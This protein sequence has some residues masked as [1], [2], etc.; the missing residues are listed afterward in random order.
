[1]FWVNYSESK[2][3][4]NKENRMIGNT[5]KLNGKEYK[6]VGKEKRSYLLELDGKQYKA[7]EEK[8]NKIL[9][10]NSQP[11][12]TAKYPN[13][14]NMVQHNRIFNKNAKMPETEDEVMEL[15]STLQAQ[16][17]PENLSC[18]GEASKSHIRASIKRI[19]ATWSELEKILGRPYSMED[20]SDY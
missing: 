7:T 19:K 9:A 2:L 6:V 18:D 3:V 16:L 4:F 15:F 1:M 5:V 20:N 8:I 10:Q 17:S 12:S 11:V 14:E 13:V